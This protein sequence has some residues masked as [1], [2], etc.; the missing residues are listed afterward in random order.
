MR[1]LAFLVL[2]SLP[3]F[4]NAESPTPERITTILHSQ[5]YEE[6]KPFGA[7]ALD[8]LLSM[9]EGGDIRARTQV[10]SAL[11]YLSLKSE[12]ARE[13]LYKDLHTPD[14]SLRLQVQWALGRVSS[15]E[16]V[17]KGLLVIRY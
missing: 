16:S 11:Y 10:S 15:D 3:I 5:R 17:V 6:L 14:E 7:D 1:K 4:A 9:Y 2:L 13:L 12:R 8:P